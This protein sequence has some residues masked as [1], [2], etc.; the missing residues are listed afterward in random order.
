MIRC[1]Q[2]TYTLTAMAMDNGIFS[3][4]LAPTAIAQERLSEAIFVGFQNN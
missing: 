1:K 3:T 4:F 2:I